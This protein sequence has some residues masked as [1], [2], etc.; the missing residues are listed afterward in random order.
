MPTGRISFLIVHMLLQPMGWTSEMV[1]Q[2]YN[3]SREKQDAYALI[4]HTRAS[5]VSEHNYPEL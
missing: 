4:S 2:T 3:V 1:A 5:K